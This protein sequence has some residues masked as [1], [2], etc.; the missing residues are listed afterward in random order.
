MSECNVILHTVNGMPFCDAPMTLVAEGLTV[1]RCS[2]ALWKAAAYHRS[3]DAH[4]IG[5]L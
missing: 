3:C 2:W 1:W 4:A 5:Q